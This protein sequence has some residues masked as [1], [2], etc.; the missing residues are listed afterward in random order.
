MEREY[1]S[2]GVLR[3]EFEVR[4]KQENLKPKIREVTKKNYESRIKSIQTKIRKAGLPYPDLGS[5]GHV[6]G[7]CVH[8]LHFD[9][10]TVEF[11]ETE[12]KQL[13]MWFLEERGVN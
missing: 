12:Y 11:D 1:K 6:I 3:S 8:T 4:L 5:I 7:L 9:R 10:G 13:R 2:I